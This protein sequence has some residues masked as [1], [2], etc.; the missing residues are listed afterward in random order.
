MYKVV[1]S[2][3]I[4]HICRIVEVEVLRDQLG[5]VSKQIYNSDS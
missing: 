5:A 2:D 4:E 3:N 1:L